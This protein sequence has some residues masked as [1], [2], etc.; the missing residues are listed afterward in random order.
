MVMLSAPDEINYAVFHVFLKDYFP[1]RVVNNKKV[2]DAFYKWGAFSKD[3]PTGFAI[4]YG[5][6]PTIK[7]TEFKCTLVDHHYRTRYGLA[8]SDNEIMIN[9][10]LVDQVEAIRALKHPAFGAPTAADLQ[11]F[12]MIESVIMAQLVHW[13]H[14]WFDTE[15]KITDDWEANE[16]RADSFLKDAYGGILAPPFSQLCP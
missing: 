10:K 6:P 16:S 12:T 1:T 2:F 14:N 8:P 4:L 13:T 5:M 15:S 11:T 3:A 9:K 7:V